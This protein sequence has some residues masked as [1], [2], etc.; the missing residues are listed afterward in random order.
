MESRVKNAFEIRTVHA[1][2]ENM[3]TFGKFLDQLEVQCAAECAVKIIP[4][5]NFRAGTTELDE[6]LMLTQ[7]LVQNSTKLSIGSGTA[8]ELSGEKERKMTYKHFRRL[9]AK[10]EASNETVDQMED[11]AWSELNRNCLNSLYAVNIQV[12]LFDKECKFVNLNKFSRAES[13]IHQGK[14]RL[15]GIHEPFLYV[16]SRATFFGFHLEDAD[17]GAINYLHEGAPKI[18]YFVPM[19]EHSNLERLASE[20]GEAVATTCTNFIRHKA[21][22]IPPSTLEGNDIRF[23]RA[24]QRQGEF[25][26]TFPGGYHSGFNGG[27]NKA[28]SIN[29]ASKKWLHCFPKF[30]PCNCD[31]EQANEVRSVG[32]ALRGIH[33]KEMA[34][35][36]GAVAFTCDIC[37]KSFTRKNN[38]R[39]HMGEVH[40]TQKM[41][42]QCRICGATFVRKSNHGIHVKEFHG[43]VQ[44]LGPQKPVLVPGGVKPT[45]AGRR[46]KHYVAC[47]ICE[48][49][50][51]DKSCLKRHIRN[52]HSTLR[53]DRVGKAST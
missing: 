47:D 45:P 51:S 33:A 53:R 44:L 21:L 12:S 36:R 52:K 23:S 46:Y 40:A 9:T 26:V 38:L 41:K 42:H 24:V 5:A 1:T 14:E 20:F 7:V 34:R 8:F 13:M 22:M 6:S 35:L 4:P 25:I 18:W 16:G 29:F 43:N 49:V 10:G 27:H 30:C 48:L 28:E 2:K 39:R 11:H 15:T 37:N 3:R 17:L 19:S 31:T 50:V 32:E